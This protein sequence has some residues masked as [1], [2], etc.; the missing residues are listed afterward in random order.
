G[1]IGNTIGLILSSVIIVSF[2]QQRL[3]QLLTNPSLQ[4]TPGQATLLHTVVGSTHY[5]AG[6]LTSFPTENIPALLDT[7]RAAFIHGMTVSMI[8]AMVLAILGMIISAT[9]IR[10]KSLI[11]SSDLEKFRTKD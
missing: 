1:C 9:L 2:S 11:L 4:L 6:Q 7:L 10:V 5:N 3:D 8:I